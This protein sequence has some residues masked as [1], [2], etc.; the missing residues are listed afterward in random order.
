MTTASP[1]P[2]ELTPQI[3]FFAALQALSG[4]S[5]ITRKEWGDENTYGELRANI[6]HIRIEGQWHTWN[7]SQG[8]MLAT[9]WILLD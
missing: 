4:G 1:T 3:D 2:I 5:R 8:D 7:I 9:D 6:V